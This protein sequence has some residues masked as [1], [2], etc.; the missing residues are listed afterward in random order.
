MSAPGRP[1]SG[2]GVESRERRVS[3]TPQAGPVGHGMVNLRD[4]GGLPVG[5]GSR[6]GHGILY[7]SDA[8][9]PTDPAPTHVPRWPPRLVVDL[10]EPREP[11]GGHPLA[12]GGTRVVQVPLL[13]GPP[14]EDWR[15]LPPMTE[16][17]L[18]SLRR[19]GERI[20][21]LLDLLVG[22]DGP[23][24]VHCAAGKDRTGVMI[25]VLLRAAGVSRA[26][27]LDDYLRTEPNRAALMRRLA[28]DLT[29]LDE[30]DRLRAQHLAG[31]SPAA[32]GAVLDVLDRAPGGVA[33]WLAANDVSPQAVRAWRQRLV[34]RPAAASLPRRGRPAG[35][36]TRTR[37]ESRKA[38]PAPDEPDLPG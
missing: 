17:Y 27:V 5:R 3:V 18:G 36:G 2:S 4:L 29:V 22:L 11:T 24:L 23:V 20:A 32:L 30:E 9:Q 21:E 37:Q 1:W 15:E 14:V 12:A 6:T 38:G 8:P 33:G 28:W 19:A 34:I 31:T 10:R 26:A 25:A 13:A 7:R 16:L 35:T